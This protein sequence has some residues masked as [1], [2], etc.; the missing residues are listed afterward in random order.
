MKIEVL[1][2]LIIVGFLIIDEVKY[3]VLKHYLKKVGLTESMVKETEPVDTDGTV[4]V[5][6]SGSVEITEEI[7]NKLNYISVII[8]IING[9]DIGRVERVGMLLEL[10][11]NDFKFTKEDLDLLLEDIAYFKFIYSELKTN[12]YNNIQNPMSEEEIEE[13]YK[14]RS[15]HH[16]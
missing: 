13:L 9:L 11:I 14:S 4:A 7:Q 8:G 5:K 12:L 15:K 16:E 3:R 2:A 10:L 6:I 1:V